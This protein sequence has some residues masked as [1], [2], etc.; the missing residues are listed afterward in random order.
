MTVVDGTPRGDERLAGDLAAEDPLAIL[1]RA[2][3][4]KK[5]HLKL[6]E[7]QEVDQIVERRAH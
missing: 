3:S 5:V 7:F 6:L 1:I 2:Q 4:A